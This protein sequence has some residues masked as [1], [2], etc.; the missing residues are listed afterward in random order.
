MIHVIARC[1][2]KKGCMEEFLRILKANV[3]TVLAEAGCLRYEP[4]IDVEGGAFVTILET[5]ESEAH[6]KAHL[7]TPHMAAYREA[8]TP[9]RG[10]TI[11]HVVKPA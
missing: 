2:I 8:V 4:C 7:A 9:L 6:L 5:W 11:L 10:E 3:P 1:E